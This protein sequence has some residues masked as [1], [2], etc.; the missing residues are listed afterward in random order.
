MTTKRKTLSD[1][2]IA[3]LK[4][5]AKPYTVADPALGGHY[6]RV[7]PG[8][9]KNFVALART[10]AGKLIWHTIGKTDV[11]TIEQA[12]DK[13]REAIKAIK[14]GADRHGPQAFAAVAANWLQ[15]H[16][17]AK[18]HISEKYTRQYL[19]KWILPA[20]GNRDFTSIRRGDVAALLDHIEDK[21][22]PV[23]AD[24]ALKRISGICVWYQSRHDDY[25]S[26]V[27]KGMRRSN[28]K[29]RSRDRI[30][31]D[32]ELRAIWT[33]AAANGRFGAFVRLC[34]LTAQR[35]EKVAAMRWEDI[36][37]DGTWIIPSEAREKGNAGDLK[38]TPAAI[39]IIEAQPRF[40]GNPYV[41][42]GRGGSHF[43]G[44]SKA[45][46]AF[47]AKARISGWTIH[48]L[49]RTARSLMSRAGVLEVHAERVMGHVQEG[50]KGIYDRHSY[51]E[52][53][54][55]ALKALDGLLQS[56]LRGPADKV[57]KLHHRR[58]G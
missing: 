20:W 36:G 18:G 3:G 34:L 43:S 33:A 47:D 27:V 23:A 13:A 2:A 21:A 41:F 42:A 8:G 46:A 31:T 22:G 10:P 55:F 56:I 6:V 53:K 29:E 30:L 57:V 9:S 37:A 19:D 49:R 48:D 58:A 40:A 32:D 12:R 5:Q 28:T 54:A 25:V 39:K 16:V 7:Q 15:R 35:R 51:F 26:P 11:L 4:P 50:V 38:L 52:E 14:S 17:Q 45:K 44:Y 24:N 1:Q